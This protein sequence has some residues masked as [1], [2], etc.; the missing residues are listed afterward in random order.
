MRSAAH[1]AYWLAVHALTLVFS[2]SFVRTTKRTPR[3]RSCD[4]SDFAR[5]GAEVRKQRE[6]WK[7]RKLE[8]EVRFRWKFAEHQRNAKDEANRM[9]DI[10]AYEKARAVERARAARAT[11]LRR[12]HTGARI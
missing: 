12:P 6:D 9:R 2:A 3:F 4:P 1:I 5:Y 8:E 7:R 11:R 10:R